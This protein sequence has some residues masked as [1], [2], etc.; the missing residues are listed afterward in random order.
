MLSCDVARLIRNEKSCHGRD[1]CG[2]GHAFSERNLGDRFLKFLLRILECAEPLLIEGR[3]DLS[4]NN[5]AHSNPTREQFN[6]PLAGE[7]ENRAFSRR[8]SRSSAPA[9]KSWLGCDIKNAALR[10]SYG[11]QSKKRQ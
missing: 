1:F 5:R 8:A 3:H 4:R 10:I 2:R 7:G 9:C 6:G 11:G